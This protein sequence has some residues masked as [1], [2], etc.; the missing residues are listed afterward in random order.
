M[1]YHHIY[2]GQGG[3]E[4]VM[5]IL[6]LLHVSSCRISVMEESSQTYRLTRAL[7]PL[8]RLWSKTCA[9]VRWEES[10]E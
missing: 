10:V 9:F 6:K 3:D 1:V 7:E 8:A 4:W 5:V 2:H